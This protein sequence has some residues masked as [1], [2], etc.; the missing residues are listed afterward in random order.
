MPPGEGVLFM[1]PMHRDKR[2]MRCTYGMISYSY[3]ARRCAVRIL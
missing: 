1:S 3:S 2:D